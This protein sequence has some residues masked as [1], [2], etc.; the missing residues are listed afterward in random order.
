MGAFETSRRRDVLQIPHRAVFHAKPDVAAVQRQDFAAGLWSEAKPIGG[1]PVER[2]LVGRGIELAVDAYNGEALRFHPACPFRLESGETVRLPTMTAA[3]VA[4][5]GNAFR[6]IHRTALQFN[7]D[8]KAQVRGLGD[9]KKML[10]QAKG[11]VVKLCNDA[12]ISY[13]LQIAE[14]IETAL[15][16]QA[17]G[18]R[19]MWACLS[20][21][22]MAK[23]PVLPG[24]ECLLI[25][26]DNDENETGNYA[27]LECA[28]R[29][30]SS[31][32]ECVIYSPSTIGSDFN[33]LV[34]RNAA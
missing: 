11:S 32:A 19:H 7:G 12:D 22:T 3:M 23:F 14:G 34:G 21:G 26:A 18:F 4:I 25:F 8:G 16:C 6:G 33:D 1:T 9:A 31:G 29:W 2:Y 13:G 24:I 30:S 5:E 27:A 10:G 15:S 20:A 28:D 17:L